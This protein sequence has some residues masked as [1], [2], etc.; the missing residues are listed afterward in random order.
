MLTGQLRPKEGQAALLEP[1]VVRNTES[2][3]AQIGLCFEII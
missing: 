2:V 1:D 3:Q